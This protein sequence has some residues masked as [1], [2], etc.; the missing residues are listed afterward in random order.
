[1][2]LCLLS[3]TMVNAENIDP[4]NDGSKYA[5]AENVGWLNAEPS[6]DGGPGIQ[7]DNLTLTGWMWG[8]NAGWV[9]L[10]CVNTDTQA[11]TFADTRL[12]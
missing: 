6:G 11:L 7:V 9:S 8:E 5:Y 4:T 12:R 1:M 10:S 3:A 2:A